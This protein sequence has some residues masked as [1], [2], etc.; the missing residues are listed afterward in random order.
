MGD[1]IASSAETIARTEVLGASSGGAL[2]SARESGVVGGKEW[3]AEIGDPR[4][5]PDHEDAHGQTVA[6]D[7]DFEVGDDTGPGPGMMGSP[8]N[9]CNCRCVANFIIDTDWNGGD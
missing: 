7:D 2:M 6:L 1:R 3:I 8:E 5:R 4:T 9:D